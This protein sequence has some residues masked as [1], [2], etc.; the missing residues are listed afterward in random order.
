MRQRSN[1][2]MYATTVLGEVLAERAGIEGKF[3]NT[4]ELKLARYVPL[5]FFFID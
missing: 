4:K 1:M 3:G 5:T 2:M